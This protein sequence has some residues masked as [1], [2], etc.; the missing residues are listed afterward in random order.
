MLLK[1][2]KAGRVKRIWSTGIGDVAGVVVRESGQW[3]ASSRRSDFS[4][5]K[6]FQRIIQQTR[7]EYLRRGTSFSNS[8]KAGTCLYYRKSMKPSMTEAHSE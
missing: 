5:L 3:G 2:G 7:G 6:C 4:N 1:T 8:L